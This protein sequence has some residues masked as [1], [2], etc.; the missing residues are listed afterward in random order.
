MGESQQLQWLL[1]MH[2]C[3]DMN[4]AVHDDLTDL[5]SDNFEKPVEATQTRMQLDHEVMIKIL[6]FVHERN[7]FRKDR[8]LRNINTGIEADN[9]VNVHNAETIGKRVLSCMESRRVSDELHFKV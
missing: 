6:K 1:S 9:N 3:A 2:A 7:P 5:D 8:A 4:S